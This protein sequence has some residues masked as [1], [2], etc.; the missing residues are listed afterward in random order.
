M[1]VHE[2]YKWGCTFLIE[3]ELSF[4]KETIKLLNEFGSKHLNCHEVTK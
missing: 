4:A 2:I 1:K 3:I